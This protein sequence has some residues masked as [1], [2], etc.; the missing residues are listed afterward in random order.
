MT[1]TI[2]VRSRA[3]PSAWPRIPRRPAIF[4]PGGA[5]PASGHAL[6]AAG[7]RPHA[8]GDPGPRRGRLLSRPRG[9][10]DRGGA[11]ADRR[12]D[13]ARRPR[14][15]RREGPQAVAV[16]L[17]GR[18][19]LHDAGA[20]LRS[21]AGGDGAPGRAR[22]APAA[23]ARPASRRCTAWPRSRS[24]RFATATG[25]SAIP[26]SPA[27]ARA[28]SATARACAARGHD[29]SAPG[30][31]DGR[32]L[33][34]ARRE[35]TTTHFSVVDGAGMVVVGDD[36]VERLLRQRAGGA[37]PR[38]SLE[39]R[40]G[41]LRDA[42][43]RA[44]HLRP[45][46]GR[47]QRRRARQ[48]NALVDVPVDR[49]RPRKASSPGA[50]PADRRSRRRTSRC[51]SAVLLRGESLEAAVAAPRFHQQDFP[52]VIQIE[53]DRFDPAWIEA[54]RKMGHEI[55][56]R[57]QDR[58]GS[59]HRASAG[60]DAAAVADPRREGAALVVRGPG[61]RRRPRRAAVMTAGEV[62]RRSTAKGAASGSS[63]SASSPAHEVWLALEKAPEIALAIREMAVRG[64]PAIGVAAAYGAAFSMRSGASTPPAERFATARRCSPRRGR[65]RSTS[66]P[67]SSAWSGASSGAPPGRRRRS[68]T[69]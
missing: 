19:H 34:V 49:G 64:A 50:R 2:S 44:Q 5:P 23:S 12:P 37:G 29:R 36:D 39:Q 57:G 26:P 41:R 59:R 16:P 10:R 56:E 68:S 52:D 58:E 30:D 28:S 43:R 45:D 15:L 60:R 6:P 54:L 40:D 63:T 53:R 4:L 9:A 21:G 8:R 46:P 11:E 51:C 17:R 20:F 69:P 13:H 42:A 55:R 24:A 31:A 67:R 27:C 38:L 48:A 33:G 61:D 14:A 35:A 1:E 32:S 65:R 25:T 3:K 7:A 22:R 62:F 18:R 66:S 47:G